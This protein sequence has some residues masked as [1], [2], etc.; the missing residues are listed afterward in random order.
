MGNELCER[1]YH[2][3]GKLARLVHDARTEERGEVRAAAHGHVVAVG[4]DHGL[5][6]QPLAEFQRCGQ[7]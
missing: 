5:P 3:A 6:A 2:V 7:K 1:T 4:V